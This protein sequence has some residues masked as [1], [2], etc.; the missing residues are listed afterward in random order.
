VKLA[1]ESP[2]MRFALARA[3]QRAGRTDDA[4][5]ERAEFLRLDRAARAARSGVQSVGGKN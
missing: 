5:R 1:P 3:Y 4:T 2:E